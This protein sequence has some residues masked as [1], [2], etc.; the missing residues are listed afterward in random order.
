MKYLATFIKNNNF[1]NFCLNE[2]LSVC[3]IYGI[4]NVKYN[5]ETFSYD[6]KKEPYLEIYFDDIENPETC[7]KLIDR[8][9]LLKSIIKIYGEGETLDEVISDIEKNN[10]EE[11]KKEQDSPLS[12][13]FD[14]DFRGLSESRK[15]QIEM[16]NKFDAFPMKGKVDISNSER[17]FIIFRNV[18]ENQKTKK[19]I[20]TKYFFGRQISAKDDKKLRF[21][22]KYDLVHRKYI[23][24]TSTDHVLSFLMTNFAQIKEGQM[25]ID[26]FVGTGSLL[27]PPSIYKAICFGCDLDVRVLRG[28]SVGYT[29][30]SEEDKTPQKMKGDIF[31]NFDDYNLVRPQII[32]QDINKS[33]FRKKNFLFDAIVCDPPYGWRAGVRKTGLSSTKK[34]KREKRLEKKRNKK[35][36]NKD[37]NNEED[38]KE[39][40]NNE[41]KND[42]YYESNNNN[43]INDDENNNK[44]VIN[45]ENEDMNYN[46]CDTNGEKRMFLP[47]SH[48]S[49]NSIFDG[50][51][52]FAIDNLK[53]GGFLVCLFPVKKEKE[54]EDL[55]N[56]PINFPRHPQ[57]KII[58][59]CENINSR[60]RSR[61]CL[62]YKKIS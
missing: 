22:T 16:I 7:Q 60:L 46:Y 31:S 38:E 35:N 24:P 26:P 62:V 23:G 9:T 49:V 13:R 51:I 18:V 50:L 33:G 43:Q 34:E 28:Y 56:H 53:V 25:V 55:V 29:R 14:I 52:N 42:E 1:Y 41:D 37:N 19:I 47:T 44:N 54:E 2:L 17:I 8:A 57:F 39:I 45:I 36:K 30:K 59:A 4:K 6:I 10:K 11:I 21:Y 12:F 20:S 32:R 61:W 27:I 3:E 5:H 15:T 58:S 40:P 48:C